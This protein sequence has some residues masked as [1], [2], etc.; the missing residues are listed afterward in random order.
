IDDSETSG[1]TITVDTTACN[2]IEDEATAGSWTLA[3]E[4]NMYILNIEEFVGYSTQAL[5]YEEELAEFLD[6]NEKVRDDIIKIILG[7]SGDCKNFSADKTFANIFS[8]TQYGSQ[9]SQKQFHGG[10]SPPVKSFYL[11][12]LKTENV[13]D[14]SIQISLFK[15]QFF[16]NGAVDF[17]TAGE[18]KI[19]PYSFKAVKDPLRDTSAV[20]GWS[21][22]E[23]TA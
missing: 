6:C 12:T 13:M 8:L 4:Y 9:S 23:A 17:A 22:K 15:G 1:G 10:F 7:F 14:K 3:A 21:I 2:T 5:D 20:N 16:G 11:V 18:Y 19:V